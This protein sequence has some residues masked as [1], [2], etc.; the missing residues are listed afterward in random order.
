MVDIT[1]IAAAAGSLKTA[2]DLSKA[3]LELRDAAA[4]Q[5]KVLEMQAQISAALASAIAAQTDQMAMLKQVEVLDAEIARLKAWENEKPKYELIGLETGA[6][7]YMLKSDARGAE[8]PHWLCP[9]C[10]MNGKKGY[11]TPT[12]TQSGRVWKHMCLECSKS[13]G[14]THMPRWKP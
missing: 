4:I 12:G 9:Q 6:V 13:I 7:V 5:G 10:F 14:G 3:A 8:P 11:T 1:A 2:Y